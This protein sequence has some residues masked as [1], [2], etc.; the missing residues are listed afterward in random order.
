MR[1][2][3]LRWSI[4]LSISCYDLADA[5]SEHSNHGKAISRGQVHKFPILSAP[6]PGEFDFKPH[7]GPNEI[8]ALSIPIST[9]GIGLTEARLPHL[10]CPAAPQHG[11]IVSFGRRMIVNS[12]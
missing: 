6:E 11:E 7:R 3:S 1:A 10:G 4:S 2:G 8:S 12:N 5:R 9:F